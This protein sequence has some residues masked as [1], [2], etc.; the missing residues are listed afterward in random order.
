MRYLIWSFG[1]LTDAF[2]V[3][4]SRSLLISD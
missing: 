4:V 2:V 1:W 3:L